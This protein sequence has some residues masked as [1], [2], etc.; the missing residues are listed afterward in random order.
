MLRLGRTP[1]AR[2]ISAPIPEGLYASSQR[3]HYARRWM[4]E[5]SIRS[6]LSEEKIL[7]LRRLAVAL[8]LVFASACTQ[9]VRPVTA[10]MA[11]ERVFQ[12]NYELGKPQS[13]YVGEAV[14]TFKD[15]FVRKRQGRTM[16]PSVNFRFTRTACSVARHF[17]R[18]DQSGDGINDLIHGSEYSIVKSPTC[19]IGSGGSR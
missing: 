6:N 19:F 9:P 10:N 7:T 4:D 5:E 14:V 12:R 15:Y 3:T 2:R 1:R 8:L 18:R 13:V 17:I 16:R 11:T